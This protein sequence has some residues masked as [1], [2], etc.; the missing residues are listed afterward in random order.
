MSDLR[1]DIK[2]SKQKRNLLIKAG[3]KI[4]ISI[5]AVVLAV[6]ILTK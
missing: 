4:L 1:V 6:L 3:I 5:A 2:T